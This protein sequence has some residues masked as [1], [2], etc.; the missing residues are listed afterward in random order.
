MHLLLPLML[1]HFR[2]TAILTLFASFLACVLVTVSFARNPL[3][4]R[5]STLDTYA[6]PI[7]GTTTL[8]AAHELDPLLLVS[9]LGNGDVDVFLQPLLESLRELRLRRGMTFPNVDCRGRCRTKLRV[10][11][12]DPSATFFPFPAPSSRQKS[13]NVSETTRT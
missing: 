4:Q 10:S 11:P 13:L 9:Q 8:R 5:A 7:A 3:L 6:F 1:S 2:K 12:S